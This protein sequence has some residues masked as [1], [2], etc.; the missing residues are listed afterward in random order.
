MNLV[1]FTSIGKNL[2]TKEYIAHYTIYIKFRNR[3]GSSMTVDFRIVINLEK[4]VG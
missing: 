3:Q 2:D 4:N 1:D